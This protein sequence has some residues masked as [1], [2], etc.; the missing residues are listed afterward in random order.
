MN[1]IRNNNQAHYGCQH[2]NHQA[3]GLEAFKSGLAT[4]NSGQLGAD[5]TS[6]L[7]QQMLAETEQRLAQVRQM[8]QMQLQMLQPQPQFNPQAQMI[9]TMLTLMNQMMSG[10]MGGL[11]KAGGQ[12]SQGIGQ[13]NQ[14][15]HSQTNP[16]F[17]VDR[18]K[19]SPKRT[20]A[21]TNL[22]PGQATK[23][24]N[25]TSVTRGKNGVVSIGFKDKCGCAKSLMVKDG[26]LSLDGGKTFQKLQNLGQILKL[27]NG[28]VVAIGNSEQGNGKKSLARVTVSDS[29]DAIRVDRPGKTNIYDVAEM[30][31]PHN[32]H[33]GGGF[34]LSLSSHHHQTA[35]GS[36]SGLNATF[37]AFSGIA[38]LQSSPALHLKMAGTK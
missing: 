5:A 15:F 12:Q 16:G 17:G 35:F 11:M 4:H 8:R 13:A 27:P 9:M 38:P 19:E 36:N 23:G 7:G 10:I 24:P 1:V 25:G 6:V 21:V 34:S 29:V 2:H 14:A 33:Q 30:A 20:G 26:Q 22:Q 28:D 3:S 32:G 31:Q 37:S 18:A